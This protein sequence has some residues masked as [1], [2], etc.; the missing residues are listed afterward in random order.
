RILYHHPVGAGSPKY[1]TPN[2]NYKNPPPPSPK[3]KNTLNLTMWWG[4]FWGLLVWWG[5][6]FEIVCW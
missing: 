6:V 2:D 5:R 4:G 1:M 3:I